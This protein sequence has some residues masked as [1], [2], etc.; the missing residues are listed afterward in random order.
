MTQQQVLDFYAHPA[1]LTAA[2]KHAPLIEQLPG[3]IEAL[4]RIVQGLA[5]HEF[6]ASSFYGVAIGEERKSESHI[7]PFEEM[8]DRILALD[9]RPLT[10]ARPPERRLVGV[11]RHF[12]VLLLAMLRAKQIPARGR[13]GFGSYFNPGFFEDHVVCE[14]WNVR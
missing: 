8:L 3:D 4:V 9:G 7:R 6:V 10:F 1:A 11:C 13:C 2:G 5:I 14:Y 12:M